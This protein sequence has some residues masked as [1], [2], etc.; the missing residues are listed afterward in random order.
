MWFHPSKLSSFSISSVENCG[1]TDSQ[2]ERYAFILALGTG[3]YWK[4]RAVNPLLC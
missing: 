3:T 1:E 4:Q 2:E